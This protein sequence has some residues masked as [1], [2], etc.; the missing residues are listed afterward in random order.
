M[1]SVPAGTGAVDPEH[2]GRLL[3]QSLQQ[4]GREKPARGTAVHLGES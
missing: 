3:L 2:K 1:T 4:V